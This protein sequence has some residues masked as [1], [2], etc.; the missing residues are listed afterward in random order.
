MNLLALLIGKKIKVMTDMKVEVT[1]EIKSI[2]EKHHSIDLEESNQAN[3]WWPETKD[4]TT[5]VIYF[6]NGASKTYSNLT[7]INIEDE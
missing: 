2:E 1:L 3:D 7:Q 4:W 6:T 5:Y